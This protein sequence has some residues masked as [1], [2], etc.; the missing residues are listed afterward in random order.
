M[1]SFESVLN[2]FHLRR[3][4]VVG[5]I[6][7]DRFVYGTVSRIS[8][9]APA[10][11]INTVA[12]EE[13]IGGAGNVARYISALGGACDIVAVVGSDDVA[14]CIRG[15]LARYP[16]IA[17]ALVEA[18]GRVTTVKTRFVAYLHNTHMLRADSGETS[19]VNNGIEDLIIAAVASRL[20]S[21]SI[22]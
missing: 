2:H 22:P 17:P 14:R 19:P 3:A 8:P 4:M 13:V 21:G 9:E 6:M 7:L 16:G 11:V 18:A 12:P 1:T 20:A 5:D 15:H 10:P